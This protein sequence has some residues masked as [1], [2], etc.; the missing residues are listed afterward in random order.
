MKHLSA[1][2]PPQPPSI[3]QCMIR[4]ALILGASLALFAPA[5]AAADERLSAEEFADFAAGHTI[6]YETE[7]GDEFGAERYL[8][9]GRVTWRDPSGICTEG[10]WRAYED[11]LCFLYDGEVQCW[12]FF[13]GPN[14][15]YVQPIDDEEPKLRV[16]RRDKTPLACDS[17]QI[18]L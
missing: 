13:D 16:T 3:I 11:D 14:G 17:E 12:A 6:Y 18:D 10:G 9:G 4:N 2:V 8:D 15:R 7:D 5:I 1:L